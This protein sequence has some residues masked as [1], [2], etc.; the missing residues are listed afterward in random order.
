MARSVK[1]VSVESSV[2]LDGWLAAWLDE[3]VL[4]A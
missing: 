2:R 4:L 1:R 3:Q